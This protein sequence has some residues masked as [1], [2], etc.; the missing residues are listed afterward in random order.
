MEKETIEQLQE[1]IIHNHSVLARFAQSGFEQV[2][3]GAVLFTWDP[4]VEGLEAGNNIWTQYLSRS[5][6]ELW[7]AENG[8]QSRPGADRWG[9]DP[10]T[11]MLFAVR[12]KAAASINDLGLF[13]V[14]LFPQTD[15]TIDFGPTIH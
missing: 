12:S 9:F 8:F 14:S 10:T 11:Y 3:Q 4:T 1:L 5:D 7:M 6:F 15:G 2:G 13:L